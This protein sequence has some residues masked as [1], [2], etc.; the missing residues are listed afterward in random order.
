MRDSFLTKST[1]CLFGEEK[2]CKSFL[3]KS[4]K[5]LFGEEIIIIFF[6][7]KSTK[8]IFGEKNVGKLEL[9]LRKDYVYRP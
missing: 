7:T 4:T 6:L 1:K 9:L 5:C 8:C 2:I 3:T